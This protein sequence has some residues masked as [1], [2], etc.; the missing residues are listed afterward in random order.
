[1]LDAAHRD[2]YTFAFAAPDGQPFQPRANTGSQRTPFR[3][4]GHPG[5]DVYGDGR[6]CS[7]TAPPC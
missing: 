4:A 3:E 1:V 7:G 2:A 6:D 5:I